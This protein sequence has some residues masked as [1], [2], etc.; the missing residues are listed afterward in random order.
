MVYRDKVIRRL[1]DKD[2]RIKKDGRSQ[3][4]MSVNPK[5]VHPFEGLPYEVEYG[6]RRIIE[7][8]IELQ[9]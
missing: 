2:L 1:K 3:V 4:V 5:T 7:Q 9:Q 8:E 6:L